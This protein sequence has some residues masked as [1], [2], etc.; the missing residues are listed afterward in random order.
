[1]PNSPNVFP[2]FH[3]S[4]L[5]RFIPNDASLFPSRELERPQ[6]VETDEGE[7]W[8]VDR[9]LDEKRGRR[10]KEF[11]VRYRGYGAEEDRWLPLRDVDELEALDVWLA[12][13]G[14]DALASTSARQ[15]DTPTLRRRSPRVAQTLEGG[16]V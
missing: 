13:K 6:G 15:T 9:I 1:M 11:L 12:S 16:R 14:P 8:L 2:T 4:Q 5:R 10:G 7:E 3:A